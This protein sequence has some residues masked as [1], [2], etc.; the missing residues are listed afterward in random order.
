VARDKGL[1]QKMEAV[2][3]LF[4]DRLLNGTPVEKEE[5]DAFKTLTTYWTSATKLDKVAGE[6]DDANS[7][8][9]TGIRA[10]IAAAGKNDGTNSPTRDQDRGTS[11]AA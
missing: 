1:D 3:N 4:A 10:R 9:F 7:S 11:E 8:G 2:A 6:E 5:N